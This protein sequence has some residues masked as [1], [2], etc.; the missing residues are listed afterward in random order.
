M[1]GYT[2]LADAAWKS[3]VIRDSALTSTEEVADYRF[4]TRIRLIPDK[5]AVRSL[6]DLRGGR[7]H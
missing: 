3:P 7:P 4:L 2:Y 6:Y 5:R 1:Y